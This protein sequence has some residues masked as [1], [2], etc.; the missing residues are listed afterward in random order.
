MCKLLSAGFFRLKKDI[1][2]WLFA[3]LTI[4]ISCLTLIRY[5][6]SENGVI[7]D[8]VVNNYIQYIGLFI[9]IFVGIFVGK[10][11]SEGIIRNKIIV[12]QSRLLIYLSKF[13][14]CVVASVLC[15]L[16]Y[17]CI[18]LIIGIPLF[19]KIQMPISQFMLSILN[20]IL[21]VIVYC[22]IFNFIAMIFSEITVS[23]TINI[24]IFIT[25]FIIEASIG[26]IA[27]SS[28]YITN[29]FWDNGIETIISE[30]LNPNY[31]GDAK[32]KSA[33]IIY[34]L[35]PQGQANKIANGNKDSLCQMPIYSVIIT[36]TINLVGIYLF[37]KK[38]LK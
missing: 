36:C 29:S 32:V 11:Y 26:Y 35:I 20:T 15:Q 8:I 27:N 30:E 16:I 38:E 12:G 34:L 31:P 18:V 25:M 21:I 22:S 5:Y 13:I 1:T 10:E 19:G 7:L 14:I 4:G 2:F 6:F 24:L 17:I 37:S 33:K 23:I 3:I 9:A 28:K